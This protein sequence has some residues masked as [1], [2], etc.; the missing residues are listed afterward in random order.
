MK[1]KTFWNSFT[2]ILHVSNSDRM[3]CSIH[4]FIR[5]TLSRNL[6][7]VLDITKLLRNTG[8]LGKWK[9]T[10]EASD[11]LNA[12][13]PNFHQ[14]RHEK[15]YKCLNKTKC[16][17]YTVLYLVL[18]HNKLFKTFFCFLFFTFL[19]GWTNSNFNLFELIHLSKKIWK[20]RK[21]KGAGL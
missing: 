7:R 17:V 21:I 12:P 2:L 14:W 9:V 16:L 11:Y 19:W 1:L 5:Q 6:R 10:S 8:R 13:E 20:K 15:K 18:D 4:D 3:F